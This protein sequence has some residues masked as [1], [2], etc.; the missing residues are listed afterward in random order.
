[1]ENIMTIV[2]GILFVGIGISNYRGNI[3]LLHSYHRNRVK[4]EDEPIMGK[5]C[6]IGMLVIAF[7]LIAQGV[8]L[9]VDATAFDSIAMLIL[10]V[11][12]AIGIVLNFYAIIKYNKGVF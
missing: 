4:K 12:L 11:G 8:L 9:I 1:M 3:S 5:I 6:G 10:Y 7:S 2:I